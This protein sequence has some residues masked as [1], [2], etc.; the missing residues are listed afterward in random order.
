MHHQFSLRASS[1]SLSHA[2]SLSRVRRL[3]QLRKVDS[4]GL[5]ETPPERAVECTTKVEYR[6]SSA[7]QIQGRVVGVGGVGVVFI[8]DQGRGSHPGSS[9]E[10]LRSLSPPKLRARHAPHHR[11]AGGGPARR[12]VPRVANGRSRCGWRRTHTKATPGA[13]SGAIVPFLL[14]LR[15]PCTGGHPLQ[16]RSPASRRLSSMSS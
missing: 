5:D 9:S 6:S 11:L 16:L 14:P 8:V 4:S 10:R 2:S 13:R 7:P 12:P 1:L 3:R 15:S